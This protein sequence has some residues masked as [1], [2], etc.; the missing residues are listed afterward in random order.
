MLYCLMRKGTQNSV[1]TAIS[2]SNAIFAPTPGLESGEEF[3]QFRVSFAGTFP[4][5]TVKRRSCSLTVFL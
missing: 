5:S 3:G 4:P 1:I 2:V